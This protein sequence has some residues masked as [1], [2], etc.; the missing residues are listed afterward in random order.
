MPTELRNYYPG[1][2]ER[3][4]QFLRDLLA[5]DRRPSAVQASQA[6]GL[7]D[8][9]DIPMTPFF[10]AYDAAKATTAGIINR[11]P[12]QIAGGVGLAGLAALPFAR[13]LFKGPVTHAANYRRPFDPPKK[14]ERPFEA[15]YPDTIP[16][17]VGGRLTHDIDGR[18]L[19]AQRVVGRNV[20][21]GRDE[22]FP[23]DEFDALSNATT[24][25]GTMNLPPGGKGA[26]FGLTHMD[27]DGPAIIFLSS[28][29]SKDRRR[30]V[31]AHELGH[32]IDELAG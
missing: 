22:A 31:Y 19:T 12:W 8:L 9:V 6:R 5:G 14:P 17:D 26:P 13:R 16:A 23:A 2:R 4:E 30:R 18:P 29:L 24:K 7:A 1:P 27:E 21:G 32:A 25:Y 11:D 20:V 15:D 3:T 10:G 28:A